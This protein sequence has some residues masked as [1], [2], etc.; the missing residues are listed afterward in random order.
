MVLDVRPAAAFGTGHVPGSLNV[1][2]GGQF[3]SWC[4]QLLDPA[5]QIVLV[6]DDEE[7]VGEAQVRLARVGLEGV[8]GYLSG[9]IAAWDRAGLPLER[10]PQ[11]AVS[12]LQA[13]LA[14]GDG[15]QVVDVRRPAEYGSGHVPGAVSIP[16][17][18]LDRNLG[19]L[20]SS[21]PTA[22]ICASGYR[23][24]A[25]TS[26]LRRHG[27]EVIFNVVGGTGA[28]L[29]AGYPAEPPQAR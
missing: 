17:D 15:L 9:G 4:G 7:S 26:L 6:A 24:S 21:R 19:R 29:A 20:D 27:F 25:A 3:A 22:V 13:R 12:E 23:S 28:W 8:V 14:E 1:G 18:G 10:V 5:R 16:L 2:L 11:V